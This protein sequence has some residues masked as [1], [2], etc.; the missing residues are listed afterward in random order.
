MKCITIERML[1]VTPIEMA[2]Q[3]KLQC[4]VMYH[5]EEGGMR[6]AGNI[7]VKGVY[8][9]GNQ[10]RPLKEVI[11]LDI[12]APFDKLVE[13]DIFSIQITD[14][15]FLVQEHHLV[16]T[17]EIEIQGVDSE[18]E[19]IEM[20][21]M[22]E[23]MDDVIINE[24]LA[25]LENAK[26]EE[27]T[28]ELI[29][30]VLQ[31]TEQKEVDEPKLEMKMADLVFEKIEEENIEEI[32]NVKNEPELFD[33]KEEL[34]EDFFDG[35]TVKQSYRMIVLK[36]AMSYESVASKYQV[37]L[38]KLRALNQDKALEGDMLV[39]LPMK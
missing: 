10:M 37:D 7:Y 19:P 27:Q 21:R 28:I 22:D 8:H 25:E 32:T 6:A 33:E 14:S 38:M 1:D 9:D 36:Q 20:I 29:E 17:I 23:V 39:F 5:K 34:P 18:E 26:E 24:E 30:E 16:L 15:H 4:Q 3:V 31:K 35:E 13:E 11:A 2:E 12:F